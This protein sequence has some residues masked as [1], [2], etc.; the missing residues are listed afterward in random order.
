MIDGE[1]FVVVGGPFKG[2]Q[3]HFVRDPGNIS[4]ALAGRA[5]LRIGD[6]AGAR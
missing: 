2:H 3:G 1:R 6:G 5:M 4:L